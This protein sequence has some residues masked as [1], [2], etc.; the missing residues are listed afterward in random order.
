MKFLWYLLFLTL[1]VAAQGT[2]VLSYKYHVDTTNTWSIKE[3]YAQ[4]ENF[5]P[6]TPENESLGFRN[7]SVWV[8]V[9][10]KNNQDT[11]LSNFM[12]FSYPLHDNLIVHAYNKEKLVEEYTTGDL[13]RFD[14]RKE[15]TGLFT[16]PYKLEV[17]GSKEWLF[18]IRS[19]SSLNIGIKFYTFEEYYAQKSKE[20]M[21]LGS[22]YVIILMMLMYNIVLYFIIRQKIYIDYVIFH[23]AYFFTHFSMN[24]LAF[25]FLYPNFPKLNLYFIPVW[26]ILSNYFSI[27][28]TISYL[29]LEEYKYKFVTYLH[30]LMLAFLL[31]L[32]LSFFL[33]YALVATTMTVMSMFSVLSLL[34]VS[35]YIWYKHRTTSA[36]VFTIAWSLL[37]VGAFITELQNMGV[38]T[39]NTLTYYAA[40]IGALFELTLLSLSLAYG[41]TVLFKELQTKEG[42]LEELNST[43]EKK[44]QVRTEEIEVKNEELK[45]QINNKNSLFKEL[46]YSNEKLRIL[47]NTDTL[48][49][50]YNRHYFYETVGQYLSEKKESEMDDSLLMLDLDHFK[51]IN[52]KYGH[53]I[54]DKVLI[55]FVKICKSLIR[56]DDIFARFGGEEFVLFLPH[57]DVSTASKRAKKINTSLSNY[58]FECATELNVTVSIGISV[59][60]F[61]NTV[62]LE[63]L[64]KEADKA[65]YK[66]KSSGRNTFVVYEVL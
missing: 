9:N 11:A 8:Y 12:V 31:L 53:D 39:L 47:S 23:F 28:F 56:E 16:I 61:P 51:K 25:E 63:T 38:I 7:D 52:D 49:Q 35:M 44:V 5:K 60:T 26:F 62:Q 22:Y 42:E 66:A 27:K 24:G 17:N 65:L 54:G 43:L 29:G 36:K 30:W 32:G 58:L 46:R 19:Q 14:T 15:D 4:K 6:I 18:N 41:Y 45:V 57:T 37:L 59:N 40:Q 1:Y 13:H 34:I 2:E 20:E 50:S 48:T 3:A 64:F 55:S 33:P 10:I 21:F